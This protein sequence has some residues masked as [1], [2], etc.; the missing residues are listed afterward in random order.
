MGPPAPRIPA[1]VPLHTPLHGRHLAAGAKMGAFGDW[2]MPLW[3]PAGTP[4]EVAAVREGVG[5][6]D[7]SHMG[8]FAVRGPLAAGWLDSVLANDISKVRVGRAQYTLL[9]TEDGGVVDD[10]IAYRLGEEDWRLVVNAGNR[11]GDWEWLGERLVEGVDLADESEDWALV[12]V[13]GPGAFALLEGLGNPGLG[14]TA[15]FGL[16]EARIGGAAHMVA[17]TGYTGEDGVEAFVRPDL[18]EEAWD[19]LLAAGAAPCGLAAR[20]ALR[21]EAAFPLHGQDIDRTITP[22]EAGLGW[23][24]KLDKGPFTGR[25]ALRRQ[26]EEG[27][28]RRRIGL[29]PAGVARPG[30]TV[31]ADGAEA[32]RVTSGSFSPTLGRPIALALVSAATPAEARFEV[33]R[34]G[35]RRPAEGAELPFLRRPE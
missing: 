2:E 33:E 4:A 32:G 16:A 5:V 18:A 1:P 11:E 26:K 35:R 8:E 15:R 29:F 7:V 25:D 19:A 13:Q 22:Y 9:L 27:A 28:G 30:D 3:Y 17:R 21:L 34:G 20:D 23:V 31:L 6:F 14:E 24:V 12:A 10:L